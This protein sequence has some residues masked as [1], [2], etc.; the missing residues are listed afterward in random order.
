M[1]SLQPDKRATAAK[2]SSPSILV[3]ESENVHLTGLLVTLLQ[4]QGYSVRH[5]FDAKTASQ[6]LKQR[7]FAFVV[8]GGMLEGKSFA[9]GS[10]SANLVEELKQRGIPFG[11]YTRQRNGILPQ[12]TGKFC[13]DHLALTLDKT[14]QE[15]SG[16]VA[17]AVESTPWPEL[18]CLPGVLPGSPL[19]RLFISFAEQGVGDIEDNPAYSI[20]EQ[21]KVKV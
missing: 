17:A 16:A 19:D 13:Y 1:N 21:K 20:S 6:E 4:Q 15:A 7:S 2:L 14:M 12:H 9:E 8:V 10:P 18:K 5:V 11:R 3:V